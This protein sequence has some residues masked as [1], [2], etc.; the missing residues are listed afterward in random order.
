MSQSLP[1]YDHDPFL[2]LVCCSPFPII[3]I[4]TSRRAH[5]PLNKARHRTLPL[6]TNT[7]FTTFGGGGSLKILWVEEFPPS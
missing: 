6:L 1:S 2:A 5:A 7:Y 3:L 4:H